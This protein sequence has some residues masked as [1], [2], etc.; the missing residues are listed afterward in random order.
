MGAIVATYSERE[1]CFFRVHQKIKLEIDGVRRI[2]ASP[3]RYCLQGDVLFV[4]RD[5]SNTPQ[6]CWARIDS[7]TLLYNR[8]DCNDGTFEGRGD[9]VS[10][11]AELEEAG[12]GVGDR[13]IRRPREEKAGFVPVAEFCSQSL[14]DA[15]AKNPEALPSISHSD[16]EALCAEIFARRGFKVDLFRGSG[17]GGID[18]LAVN[19]EASDPSIFAVQCKQPEERPGKKRK[20]VGRPVIQQI[21]GAAKAW[22][23]SGAVIVS[24]S[25]Y[26]TEAKAF[27]DLKPAEMKVYDGRDLMDWITRFRWNEDEVPG[28]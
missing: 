4:P 8:F 7:V 27:A 1:N 5:T 18:F 13:Y 14:I 22:D 16:F 11:L 23:T 9:P 24:G 28:N 12:V 26:S 19:D 25:T 17:D 21:Y 20:A 3:F 6:L 2:L 15:L 10:T